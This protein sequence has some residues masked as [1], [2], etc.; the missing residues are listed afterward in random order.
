MEDN[1]SATHE[2]F[3]RA[4]RVE[5]YRFIQVTAFS[6]TAAYWRSFSFGD[7][8]MP[9]KVSLCFVTSVVVLNGDE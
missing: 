6:V 1:S 7:F 2:V 9:V 8:R 4:V 3:V 5:R